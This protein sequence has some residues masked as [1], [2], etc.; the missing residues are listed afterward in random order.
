MRQQT[1]NTL[2]FTDSDKECA[3]YPGSGVAVPQTGVDVTHE[4]QPEEEFVNP[5]VGIDDDA[6]GDAAGVAGA[7]EAADE[8]GEDAGDSADDPADDSAD[9]TQSEATPAEENP[10]PIGRHSPVPLPPTPPHYHGTFLREEFN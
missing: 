10:L 7:P 2:A 1:P 5:G 6:A 9:D 4:A 3:Y 8:E